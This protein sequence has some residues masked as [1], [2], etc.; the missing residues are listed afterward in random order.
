MWC[1]PTRPEVRVSR[2]DCA[3]E[4][5]KLFSAAREVLLVLA[6]FVVGGGN[7]MAQSEESLDVVVELE[8]GMEF[9][10]GWILSTPRFNANLTYAI[11]ADEL[12][13][14]RLNQLHPYE[15]FNFDWHENGKLAWYD[16][17]DGN[18]SVL[19]S[20]LTGCDKVDAVN[21][22]LDYHDLE[23]RADGSI[24]LME[25]EIVQLSVA[26]SVSD[27]NDSIRSILD[28]VLYELDSSGQVIWWWRASDVIP[29][30]HCTHCNWEFSLIDA[31]HQNAFQTLD[32]GDILLCLRNMDAVIRID[33]NSGDVMWQLG[34]LASDMVF[35]DEDGAFSQP[36]DVHLLEENR[37]LLFDNAIG[38]DS[39]G[40][41]G[42]EYALDFE[43]GLATVMETWPH[44]DGSVALSQGSIQR[45]VDGGTLIGWGTAASEAY[46]GGMVSE[47][48]ASGQLLG[49]LYFPYNHFSYRARKVPQDA[50]P[51]HIGCRN[52]DACNYD[53]QAVVHADCTLAGSPCDDG[54]PC[55]V[56][57]A[58]DTLC[59]CSGVVPPEDS[60]PS[61]C[62]D[63]IAVNFNPCSTLPVDEGS[64]QYEIQLRVDATQWASVPNSVALTWDGQ[65]PLSL[66]AGGFGTW[67]GSL[68]TGNGNWSYELVVDGIPDG[69]ERALDLTSPVT[70]NGG[71]VHA[72]LGQSAPYCPGCTDPDDPGYSPFAGDDALCASAGT[73]GCTAVEADNFDPTAFFDDGS[74]VFES[75]GECPADLN[76]DG[77]IGIADVLQILSL[78]GQL[79]D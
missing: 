26:D 40:S 5:Q 54:N 72:C 24:L 71:V 9:S 64:C 37:L 38:Q 42:M 29:P 44:P 70:W 45:L 15:G 61:Q 59:Q 12:G 65:E 53:Q 31:Y 47:Y 33:R 17:I 7:M 28:C 74:C 2:S 48:A 25:T 73:I 20:A 50:L 14:V 41:R 10:P 35:T 75:I 57:D 1:S 69:V 51:L 13:E 6:L 8:P 52:P 19:D 68:V 66:E 3:R 11:I 21:A 77:L 39:V 22:S 62:T 27:S 16:I 58:V 78:F 46:S 43:A 60:E 79:C 30:T 18:W 49:T 76:D 55:T 56:E 32:N 34:G 4:R 67:T 23:L 63:P 36:H